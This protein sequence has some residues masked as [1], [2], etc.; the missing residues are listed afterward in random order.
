MT[1]FE[2]IKAMIPTL[3]QGT[4]IIY[5]GQFYEMRGKDLV[6]TPS[7]KPFQKA[8]KSDYSSFMNAVHDPI[9]TPEKLEL[10]RAL[11]KLTQS[12]LVFKRILKNETE[13]KKTS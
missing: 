2:E 3:P 5:L 4:P 12:I 1:R 11:L 13:H 7:M 8:I 9:N 10:N 6:Y